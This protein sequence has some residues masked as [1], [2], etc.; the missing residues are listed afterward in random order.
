M[1]SLIVVSFF[2]QN[3]RNN[4]SRYDNRESRFLGNLRRID[5]ML[6]VVSDQIVNLSSDGRSDN[7][8]I[9]SGCIRCC[10]VHGVRRWQR[11]NLQHLRS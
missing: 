6:A 4:F 11:N 10:C 5:K 9:F 7:M 3:G 2:V 1:Y 8:S